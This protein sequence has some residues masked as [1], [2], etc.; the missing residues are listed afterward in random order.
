MVDAAISSLH[1]RV[2]DTCGLAEFYCEALGMQSVPSNLGSLSLGYVPNSCQLVFRKEAV[3]DRIERKNNFYWKIGIT[4]RNLDAAVHFL[5]QKG[6]SVSEPTQFKDIGYISHIKDPNGFTI[7]LLQCGFKGN[8]QSVSQG[9]RIGSQATLAHLTLRVT[10]IAAAHDYFVNTLGMRLLSVQPVTD[11]NFC[12]Y[13]YSW[14]NERLPDPDLKSV[15]NREWL[16]ARPYTLI[17]LQHLQLPAASIHYES[18]IEAGFVG[19]SYNKI[20]IEPEFVS[21][22][23]LFRLCS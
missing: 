16:W 5:E 3:S 8:E 18:S 12:L 4:V 6:V 15:A 13:F 2:P 20:N 21:G 11:H 22:T 23:D 10:N 1:L 19:F 14:S 7:E 17:E 9:H